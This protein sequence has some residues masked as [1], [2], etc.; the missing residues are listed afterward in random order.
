M[1][2]VSKLEFLA[3]GILSLTVDELRELN[4]LLESGG[5]PPIGVREP[6]RPAPESPGDAIAKDLLEDDS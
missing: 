6:R 3:S 5:A 2:E 4:R 1:S